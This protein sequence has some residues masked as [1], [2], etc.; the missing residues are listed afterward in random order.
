LASL[1]IV[2]GTSAVFG[3]ISGTTGT[4]SS[5]VSG[6]SFTGAG[7]GLTG[8]AGSLSIG[9]NAATATN[10]VTV[11][12]TVAS[13]ATGTTQA[14]TTNNTTI[15]TTAFVRSI[16]PAGVILMWSG[17]IASI[18]SGW[19]LCNGS[20]GTPDLRDRFIVGAGSTYAVNATGGSAAVTPAG[21]VSGSIGGTAIT[22]AQMPK[23]FHRTWGPP[24]VYT[25]GTVPG[26]D[27]P[28]TSYPGRGVFNG[29]TPD[30]GATDYGTWSVGGDATSGS[31]S[32]GT[33]AASTHTHSLSVS[34]TGSSQTN[35]PPYYALAYIMKT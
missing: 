25:G 21:S 24:P 22:E 5:T 3:A 31:T 10:A 12:T 17:S 32:T 19:V 30:D 14:V 9:G 16:I 6:S 1:G 27:S 26:V 15:A 13:G 4:F 33:G 11:T 8:T 23:H 18:P 34:F 35:L 28:G 20:S 7:T 29:G 2:S